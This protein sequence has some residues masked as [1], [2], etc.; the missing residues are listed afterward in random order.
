MEYCFPLF[1][2]AFHRGRHTALNVFF[3]LTTALVNLSLASLLFGLSEF[4]QQNEWGLFYWFSFSPILI[5]SLGLVL[6]DGLSA[7]LPHFIEHQ[8]K[9]LWQFHI[10]HHSDRSVDAS[11]A[12]RHHPG[13]SVL[14]FIFTLFGVLVLGAPLWFILLYQSVSVLFSQFNHS[15]INLP[16]WLDR[17]LSWVF[18]TPGMHRVHHHFQQPWTD[19]NY[20]NIFSIFDRILGT[21][22]QKDH[23]ALIFGLDTHFDQKETDHLLPLLKIPFLPHRQSENNGILPGNS[24][25]AAEPHIDRQQ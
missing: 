9:W 13:E 5:A 20:G 14:R 17:G 24:K 11:T 18:V 4:C 8:V 10:I 19:K 1:K 15:N 21:F 7:W 12:N 23:H 25:N 6:M 2:Y 3:T 16:A 22:A